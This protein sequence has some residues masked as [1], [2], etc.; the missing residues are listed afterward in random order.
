MKLALVA[1]TLVVALGACSSP[2]TGTQS[3]PAS[4]HPDVPGT[5]FTILFENEAATDVLKP[6]NPTF[7]RLSQTQGSATQY[8]SSTHPSLPN[9]ITLTSGST[10]GV[11]TD[12][13]PNDNLR[14]GGAANVADQL[15]AAGVPWRAYMESMG[16]PCNFV[17]TDLYSAH[18]DPFL[19]YTTMATDP[20]RC[21]E[22]VVDYDANFQADLDSGAYR[23]MWITPNMCHDMHNCAGPIADAWLAD[24][25]AKITASKA[26]QN[27]GALFILFDE[28]S[29]RVLGASATL[30]TIVMSP[31]LVA[32]HYVSDTYY[33]H[34]SYLATVE[35]I[36]DLP[37]LPTTASVTS[38][39]DFFVAKAAASPA[40]APGTAA[41][42]ASTL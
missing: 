33:E 6:T 38:M 14:I 27:G 11:T 9:Y 24:A 39:N 7:Y 5:V 17:S 40:P 8:V 16:A 10:N 35:D 21:A 30:T 42:G 41:P 25:V 37:R 18:H 20:A 19:Y 12:N 34:T 32:P 23:Y 26:Y 28:G 1:T 15:D 29:L 3:T 22:H 2:S 31:K 4:T 13:D 36:L